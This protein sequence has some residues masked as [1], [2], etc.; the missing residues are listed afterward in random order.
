MVFALAVALAFWSAFLAPFTG[1]RQVCTDLLYTWLH[2]PFG[3]GC[4]WAAFFA[5]FA[6]ISLALAMEAAFCLA[7]F[8]FDADAFLSRATCNLRLSLT[9]MAFFPLRSDGFAFFT[10]GSLVPFFPKDF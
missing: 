10:T 2:L 1:P 4:A 9:F 8:N 3:F 5:F 7:F 6:E